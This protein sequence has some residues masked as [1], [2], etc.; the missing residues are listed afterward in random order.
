MRRALAPLL[1][2]VAG[3][4]VGAGCGYLGADP[5]PYRPPVY[6][7][8]AE[9][10]A[11]PAAA[12]LGRNL[13][14]R[15]CAFCHDSN[16][17][18]TARGPDL[19]AETGGAA[20]TDF[21]LRTGRMPIEGPVDQMKA[22]EPVYNKE[23]REAIVAFVT[24]EFRPPGPPVPNV[25][26]RRGDLGEG[27]QVYQEHCVACHATT[28]IGGAMLSQAG[29][30]VPGPTKGIVIPD[31]Q[32]TDAIE[33]AESVR[34]GPG[35]MPVFGPRAISDQ[36]LDSLVRYMLYLKD[37][38]DTG[39]APIGRVG[40]VVEGAVGWLLGLGTLM[41]V[42]RWIGTKAGEQE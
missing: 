9:A 37:P 32:G 17:R 10:A 24:S 35:S 19:T 30:G 14:M 11:G 29:E 33:T 38:A 22:D 40:P 42:A 27:Q 36:Q 28:G 39:G 6:Y 7:D 5:E 25:D 15:D 18:G 34:T 13:Y 16:G 41:I 31:F 8:P 3:V 12:D 1:L 4:L 2:A 23:Q 20:L 21:V 26:A